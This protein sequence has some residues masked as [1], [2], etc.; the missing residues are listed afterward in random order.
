MKNQ[1]IDCT[2]VKSISA[3]PAVC[4]NVGCIRLLWFVA[5]SS[6]SITANFVLINVDED[7]VDDNDGAEVE[8]LL[9]PDDNDDA[10]VNVDDNDVVEPA[11]VVNSAPLGDCWLK[12]VRQ[13]LL[14]ID[15]SLSLFLSFP[16]YLLK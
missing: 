6:K 3:V 12:V 13:L 5:S 4:G 1:S 11:V 14:C 15:S 8:V 16:R 2:A 10:V 7:E 9:Q